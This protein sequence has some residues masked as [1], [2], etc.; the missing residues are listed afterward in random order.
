MVSPDLEPWPDVD[1]DGF[2]IWSLEKARGI[3]RPSDAVL[4]NPPSGCFGNG[5]QP[6][7]TTSGVLGLNTA[8]LITYGRIYEILLILSKDTRR[9]MVKLELDLGAVPAPISEI[10]CTSPELCFPKFGGV[11]VNPTARLALKGNC[12]AECLGD[13]QYHWEIYRDT[14]PTDLNTVIKQ[15]KCNYSPNYPN[16]N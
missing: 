14:A 9:E 3:P 12:L 6:L 11:F 1:D 16:Y 13:E 7:K 15:L 2:P 10:K 5:P 8:S 4:I